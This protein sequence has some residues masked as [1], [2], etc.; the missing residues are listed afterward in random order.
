MINTRTLLREEIALN[1]RKT[2]L[3][4][5]SMSLVQN[6][7]YIKHVLGIQIPLVEYYS[8]EIRKQIIEEQIKMQDILIS[9]T[10]FSGIATFTVNVVN[11]AKNLKDIAI[12][13]KDLILSPELMVQANNALANVCKQLSEKI[14][15][16]ITWLTNTIK[17]NIVGFTDKIKPILEKVGKTLLEQ[18]T[19]SGWLGFLSML[20]FCIIVTYIYDS[21]FVKMMNAGIEF[22]KNVAP[23]LLTVGI[24]EVLDM[25]KNF[26]DFIVNTV[27]VSKII[28]FFSAITKSVLFVKLKMAFSLLGTISIVLAPVIAALKW[29]KK[30][31]K[32]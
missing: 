30:L 4:E 18:A 25:F 26:K 24:T 31:Q 13:F 10:K 14:L 17:T 6:S 32:R 11:S 12:L 29:P 7:D 19:L 5:H 1:D 8:F 27:D 21:V 28:D 20:G 16:V 2:L 9:A 23:L 15:G 3:S 22:F